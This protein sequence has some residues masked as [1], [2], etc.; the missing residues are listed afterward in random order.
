MEG[1][2]GLR[3]HT[4]GTITYKGKEL[5]INQPQDAIKTASPC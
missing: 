2:F 5:T 1:L 4:A 3:C